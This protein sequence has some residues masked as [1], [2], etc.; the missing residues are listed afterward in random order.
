M[1]IPSIIISSICMCLSFSSVT[2]EHYSRADPT[3][4]NTT[5]THHQPVEESFVHQPFTKIAKHYHTHKTHKSSAKS[6]RSHSPRLNATTSISH[7][8]QSVKRA[9]QKQSNLTRSHGNI[10]T[11]VKNEDDNDVPYHT[12]VIDCAPMTFVDFMGARALYQ[13]IV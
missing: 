9:Y 11:S 3:S 5:F 7:R 4:E 2:S 13:V 12:I 10:A 8:L 6:T 1:M